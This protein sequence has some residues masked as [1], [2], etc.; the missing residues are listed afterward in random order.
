MALRAAQS[1]LNQSNPAELPVSRTRAMAID[2][3]RKQSFEP[4]L[5]STI[6]KY[7]IPTEDIYTILTRLALQV[8]MGRDQYIVTRELKKRIYIPLN[9]NREYITVV[10]GVNASSEWVISPFVIIAAKTIIQGWFDATGYGQNIGIAVSGNG[11]PD[12]ELGY[13]WI[14][15]ETFR[16]VKGWPNIDCQFVMDLALTLRTNLWI[17]TYLLQEPYDTPSGIFSIISSE[18][19][20]RNARKFEALERQINESPARGGVVQQAHHLHE[21][22]RELQDIKDKQLQRNQCPKVSRKQL[23]TSGG[24]T[25]EEESLK[26]KA[27]LSKDKPKESAQ[28][29]LAHRPYSTYLHRIGRRESPECQA[30]KEPHETVRHVLFECRGRRAGRRTLYR[31]LKKASVPL[32][33]AAEESPEA[34]LFAEPRAT[35][36]LLQFSGQPERLSSDAWGWDMLEEGGLGHASQDLYQLGVPTGG[37]AGRASAD[38]GVRQ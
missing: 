5:Q 10:E 2:L 8:G 20:P 24:V 28:K 6:T 17:S 3:E 27:T 16:K 37:E 26:D 29:L 30:C 34:R 32:P 19:T 33:T 4:K 7:G 38:V 15:R 1:I 11:Y 9:T 18:A 13:Q 21:V 22:E 14:H 12:D 25:F 31:A 23:A 36:G 35:Q